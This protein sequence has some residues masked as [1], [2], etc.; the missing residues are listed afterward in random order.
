MKIIKCSRPTCNEQYE[1]EDENVVGWLCKSCMDRT[2]E[3]IIRYL[4]SDECKNLNEKVFH[5]HEEKG[6]VD[7]K[8]LSYKK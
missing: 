4:E 3:Y 8:T 2:M 5:T 6:D 7:L 1:E